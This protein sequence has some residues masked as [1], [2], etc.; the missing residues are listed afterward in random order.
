M[1]QATSLS[2]VKELYVYVGTAMEVQFGL[3]ILVLRDKC[4]LCTSTVTAYSTG[5]MILMIWQNLS[6]MMPIGEFYF[7]SPYWG[8]ELW[9]SVNLKCIH[10]TFLRVLY[11]DPLEMYLDLGNFCLGSCLVKVPS[12]ACEQSDTSSLRTKGFQRAIGTSLPPHPSLIR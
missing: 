4:T 1:Q 12:E 2:A 11:R 3:C 9:L 10:F 5:S 7:Q 8:P 6:M